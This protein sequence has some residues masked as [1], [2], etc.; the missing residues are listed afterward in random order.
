LPLGEEREQVEFC[1]R[2]QRE[3]LNVRQTEALVQE[4]IAADDGPELG[5]VGRDGKPSR[6][7]RPRSEH[8]VALE[9]ELRSALG[10]KVSVTHNAK[11]KGKMVIHFA[12][13]DEFER[14]R[15]FL[16]QQNSAKTKAS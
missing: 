2:I 11:G 12:G 6:S 4:A 3:G 13:H 10:T 9:Q 5:V 1:E 14:I 15:L 16:L 8:I 7:T